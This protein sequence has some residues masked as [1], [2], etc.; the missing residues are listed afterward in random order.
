MKQ[1]IG[2]SMIVA[3]AVGFLKLEA[4]LQLENLIADEWW[5]RAAVYTMGGTLALA[6][7]WLNI[8][9]MRRFDK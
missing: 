2:A 9:L 6:T 4:A 8:K 1:A 3:Q 7:S 5:L